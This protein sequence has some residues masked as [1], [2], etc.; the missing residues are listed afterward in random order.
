MAGEER[1]GK[2]AVM[3][4]CGTPATHCTGSNCLDTDSRSDKYGK[5][6]GNHAGVKSCQANYLI[7]QGYKKIAARDFDPQNGGP[8]LVLSKRPQRVK[9]GKTDYMKQ[10]LKA[11][12]CLPLPKEQQ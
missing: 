1:K 5:Y 7:K 11:R 2:A 4:V 3:F 12:D 10:P 6:H 8:I 9:P